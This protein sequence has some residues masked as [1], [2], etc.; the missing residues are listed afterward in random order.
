[1]DFVFVA[2]AC[3][4]DTEGT[5]ACNYGRRCGTL[6]AAGRDVGEILIEDKLAVPFVCGKTH[7]PKTPRPWC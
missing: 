4:P 7:C 2:C 3:S 5:P 1:L 6:K